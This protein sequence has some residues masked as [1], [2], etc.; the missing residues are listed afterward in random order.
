MSA[1]GRVAF[2]L[3]SMLVGWFLLLG[4]I[5]LW[6]YLQFG[7]IGVVVGLAVMWL[8]GWAISRFAKRRGWW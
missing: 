5:T 1:G 3:I 4:A 8:G 6:M 7:A 2:G